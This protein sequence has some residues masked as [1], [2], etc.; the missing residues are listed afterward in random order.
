MFSFA[1]RNFI[2]LSNEKLFLNKTVQNVFFVSL[3]NMLGIKTDI[4]Y[5][6]AIIEI[7]FLNYFLIPDEKYVV[8]VYKMFCIRTIVYFFIGAQWAYTEGDSHAFFWHI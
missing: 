2:K 5:I 3:S 7:Y 6:E 1:L 4:V 8:S